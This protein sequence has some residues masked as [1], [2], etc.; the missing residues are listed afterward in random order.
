[1]SE[2]YRP[3][4][5]WPPHFWRKI[6]KL[7]LSQ[8][9]KNEGKKFEIAVL[10]GPSHVLCNPVHVVAFDM[11]AGIGCVYDYECDS[12]TKEAYMYVS[13]CVDIRMGGDKLQCNHV[14]CVRVG[15]IRVQCG[16]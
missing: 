14:H 1:M 13:T 16:M 6:E 7:K 12:A 9:A 8:N 11:Y 10:R 5:P 4:R 3:G 15:D 2:P